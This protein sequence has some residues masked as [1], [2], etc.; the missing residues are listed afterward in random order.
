MQNHG[1]MQAQW[2]DSP[3]SHVTHHCRT[4][5]PSAAQTDSFKVILYNKLKEWVKIMS[6]TYG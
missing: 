5:T 4:S 6:L 2:A 1:L 3:D